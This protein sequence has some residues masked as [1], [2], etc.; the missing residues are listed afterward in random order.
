MDGATLDQLTADVRATAAG[1]DPLDR[2]DAAIT[3]ATSLAHHGDVS[4]GTEHLLAVLALDHG[5]RAHRILVDLGVNIA[6]V[7]KELACYL[8]LS[9][10]RPRRFGHTR[11]ATTATC[12]LC[13]AAESPTRPLAH[14]PGVMICTVCARRAVQALTQRLNT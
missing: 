12:S 4:V 8:T 9:P 5:S 6:A 1:D 13:G 3:I 2:V 7:K 10:P 14:G 11:R